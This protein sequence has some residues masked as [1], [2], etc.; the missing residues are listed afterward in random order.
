MSRRVSPCKEFAVIALKKNTTCTTA[1]MLQHLC[2]G[3]SCVLVNLLSF[4]HY[5]AHLCS[6]VCISIY[7][8][9]CMYIC[10]SMYQY[11]CVWLHEQCIFHCFFFITEALFEKKQTIMTNEEDISKLQSQVQAGSV[12]AHTLTAKYEALVKD[13]LGQTNAEYEM[14]MNIHVHVHVK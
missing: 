10:I 2:C 8:S 1:Q 9:V 7:V 6:L 4:P 13:S 3:A 5:S 11:V 14:D 12:K